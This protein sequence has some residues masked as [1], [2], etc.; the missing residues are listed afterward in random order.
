MPCGDLL[1][2]YLA[3]YCFITADVSRQVY[4]IDRKITTCSDTVLY[5][6]FF[7]AVFLVK[8]ILVDRMGKLNLAQYNKAV[9]LC[10]ASLKSRYYVEECFYEPRYQKSIVV[11][12]MEIFMVNN[13]LWYGN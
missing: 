13:H 1:K 4:V 10:T 11:F 3:T 12:H 9:L 6:C 2:K 7:S 8:F 5:S